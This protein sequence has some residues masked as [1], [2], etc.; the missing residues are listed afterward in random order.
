M[1]VTYY[2]HF[3]FSVKVDDQTLLFDPFISGNELAKHI[4]IDSI[5]ADYIFISHGHADHILD[6]ERIAKKTGAKIVSIYE[7]TDW[8]QKKGVQNI[9]PMNIGGSKT[10]DFGTVKLTSSIHSS[11][12]PDG[13]YA[14]NPCG[15]LIDTPQVSFYF[16][17]D[18]ALTYDMKLIKE[19]HHRALDFAILPIGDNFT[20]GYED[21]C[22]ASDFLGVKTIIGAHYDTFGY[23]TIDKHIAKTHFEDR[24]KNL[25]LPS[26]GESIRF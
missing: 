17:G 25:M 12:F 15:F 8:F 10:F 21:A 22:I 13:S 18:T 7:I 20:M 2:G 1:L 4:D 3:C 9:H 23:I 24:Q 6:A 11:S 19:Y 5:V 26:I 16:S 14:G